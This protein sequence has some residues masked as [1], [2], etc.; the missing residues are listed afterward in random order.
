MAFLNDTSTFVS[1]PLKNQQL[2]DACAAGT[3]QEILM[4]DV[5]TPLIDGDLVNLSYVM[6]GWYTKTY[7][8][9]L[10]RLMKHD[11]RKNKTSGIVIVA[12]GDD[13]GDANDVA[14]KVKERLPGL[15]TRVTILGHIQRGGSPTAWD[16][17]LAGMLGYSAV[18]ALKEQQQGVMVGLVNKQIVFTPFDEAIKHRKGM[19]LDL[20]EMSR[21]LAL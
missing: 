4:V 9:N 21:I 8:D 20:L 10:A 12:E 14:K 19:I 17:M 11:I 18:K 7:I 5:Y 3:I 2:G 1:N 16:R 13:A 6:A 15:E